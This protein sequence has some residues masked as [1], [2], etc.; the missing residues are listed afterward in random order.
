MGINKQSVSEA[1]GRVATKLVDLHRLIAAGNDDSPEADDLRDAI[2]LDLSTM[3]DV[4]REQARWLSEDLYSLSEPLPDPATVVMT[5]K[6]QRIFAAAMDARSRED[7]HRELELLRELK[8]ALA[9]SLLS[10]FRGLAWSKLGVHAA[11][12]GFYLHA[13]RCDPKS[14]RYHALYLQT[15]EK[16]N[17][18][19]ARNEARSLLER[20]TQHSL[21]E[22][23]A[24]LSIRFLEVQEF[25]ADERQSSLRDMIPII[26]SSL[27]RIE[28]PSLQSD[29]PDS[30]STSKPALIEM[31]AILA[32]CYLALDDFENSYAVCNSGLTWEPDNRELLEIRGA[33]AYG[34]APGAIEDLRRSVQLGTNSVFPF[35]YLAHAAL[36]A[37]NYRECRN[38]CEAGLKRKGPDSV[39]SR[40][41]EWQAIA[42]AELGFARELVRTDFDTAIEVDRTNESARRNRAV[43][44]SSTQSGDPSSP[45]AW[46][47]PSKTTIRQMGLMNGPRE[48][49]V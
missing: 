49:A 21:F 9:P 48:F 32:W 43:F 39:M 36:E 1:F 46:E 42:E 37:A 19:Q 45:R 2:D 4:E 20:F 14:T 24:A 44:E 15:L 33:S 13:F 18:A 28:N 38:W 11:T 26:H 23:A 17:P 27:K 30:M 6:E 47:R 35:V 3:T 5:E 31:V 8:S 41:A 12:A 29:H 10:F 16:C 22:V 40:L 25:Q 7:W 34:R